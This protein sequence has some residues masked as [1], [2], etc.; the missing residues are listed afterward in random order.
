MLLPNG[1]DIAKVNTLVAKDSGVYSY[2]VV[3]EE[4]P[5]K[6]ATTDTIKS[7]SATVNNAAAARY[8]LLP[9]NADI[10]SYNTAVALY[11]KRFEYW[12]I[13]TTSPEKYKLLYTDVV[14]TWTKTI[15]SVQSIRYVLLPLNYSEAKL[16]ELIASDTGSSADGYYAVSTTQPTFKAST[17]QVITFQAYVNNNY[18]TCYILVPQNY[19]EARVND[20]IALYTGKYDYW[21]VYTRQ[22]VKQLS[23]DIIQSWT[24]VVNSV[25]TTR[26]MLLPTGYDE[27][28]FQQYKNQDIS[29]SSSAYYTV[30]TVYPTLIANTDQVWMWYNTKQKVTKY[31]LLPANFDVLKRNEIV[32]KDTGVFDYYTIYSTA[33]TKRADTDQILNVMYQGG[34]VFMLVPENYDQDKV[35]RGL[36]GLY[37]S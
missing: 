35:N 27:A 8:V 2:Y 28:L 16:N 34:T 23:Y 13:Y 10:P 3:Y 26:Y 31:M 15:N 11:T 21:K 32:Y 7:F 9:Q 6:K 22:P 30:T 19:D 36:A 17:D 14:K 25:S 20:A 37:V 24:K 5:S 33:P 4:S 1:Y 18:V 29:S 12:T